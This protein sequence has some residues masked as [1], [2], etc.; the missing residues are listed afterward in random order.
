[1]SQAHPVR[2]PAARLRRWRSCRRWTDTR[3]RTADER[4]RIQQLVK[5]GK[6]RYISSMESP[7]AQENAPCTPAGRA[8]EST[9]STMIAF[10]WLLHLRWGAVAVQAFLVLL[11]FLFLQ[12]NLPHLLIFIILAFGV[13]TNLLFSLVKKKR[14]CISARLFA[15]VMFLDTI[16][17]TVLLYST[18][19]P[20]NPFTFLYLV[21]ISMGAILMPA[22][23][24]WGLAFFTACG[25]A[26]LFSLPPGL[27][28]EQSCHFDSFPSALGLNDAMMLHLR[29]MWV[30]F[31]VTAFFIV[32]FV[33]RIQRALAEHQHTL[34]ELREEKMKSEKLA[35][36]ATLA[37]GAAHEFSTPLATIAVA[38]GEMLHELRESEAPSGLIEDATLIRDQVNRCKDILFHMAADAGEH[39]GEETTAIS[40]ADFLANLRDDFPE[41]VRHRLLFSDRTGGLCMAVPLRTMRRVVRNLIGNGLDASPPDAPVRVE[42]RS[43]GTMLRIEVADSGAGM[44]PD[45]ADRATEPFFTTK[46][47]GK[48][49]GLGLFLARTAAERFGGGIAIDSRPGMGTRVTLS[50]ALEKIG[51][52]RDAGGGGEKRGDIQQPLEKRA[53]AAQGCVAEFRRL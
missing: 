49:L 18:G 32:F 41:A 13:A 9:A 15:L 46:E 25:Y 37:A 17:L 51:A 1:M 50:L 33:S 45:V 52:N 24:A 3:T 44:A 6:M 38:S 35:S 14:A 20:M 12:I 7:T 36:L 40:V 43:E 16:L 34:A 2:R 8:G 26:L 22:P 30:A 10:S 31:A 39:L 47:P 29:G 21:H 23:W 19:G 48:G 4:A 11:D 27:T 5:N 53:G 42:C 28:T